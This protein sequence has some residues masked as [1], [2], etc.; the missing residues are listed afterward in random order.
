MLRIWLLGLCCFS[1]CSCSGNGLATSYRPANLIGGYSEKEVE[2]GIWRVRGESNGV[3]RRGFG[4][5]M[6]VY[7]AAELMKQQGFE[8]F[9]VL[10]QE[11]RQQSISVGGGSPSSAGEFLKLWIAGLEE[12][13]EPLPCRAEEQSRC[14]I[15]SVDTV[16]MSLAGSLG[17]PSKAEIEEDRT[18]N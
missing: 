10:D 14:A 4:K 15:L 7:R 17:I 8:R 11:G 1:L 6:A 18:G 13:Q 2:P 16:M 9:Q 5:D 3:A 12:G